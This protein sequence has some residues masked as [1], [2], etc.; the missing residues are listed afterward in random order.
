MRIKAPFHIP[1]FRINVITLTG[2]VVKMFLRL[3]KYMHFFMFFFWI[4]TNLMINKISAIKLSKQ[5]RS[6]G[7]FEECDDKNA[8]SS[9]SLRCWY[10][11]VKLCKRYCLINKL[12]VVEFHENF[13]VSCFL[14]RYKISISEY[15][16]TWINISAWV[17]IM[18]LSH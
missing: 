9:I 5:C 18:D 2:L 3:W 11:L 14:I 8:L 1:W 7:W 13:T 12:F 17:L 10:S 15:K 16:S 6:S 4:L